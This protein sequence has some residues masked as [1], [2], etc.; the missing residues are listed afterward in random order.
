MFNLTECHFIYNDIN[1]RKYDLIVAHIDSEEFRPICGNKEGVY[2]F[3][4]A[5][6]SR[7][8]I[9][10]KYDGGSLTCK[11]EIVRCDG[12][13]FNKTELREAER[14]LFTNGKY[15]KLYIDPVD[16]PVGESYEISHGQQVKTYL[17]CRFVNAEKIF[18]NGGVIGFRCDIETDSYLAWQD[19]TVAYYVANNP[20]KIII[21]EG[22]TKHILLGD[23]QLDGEIGADD[24]QFAL[25][26][27]NY[28]VVADH[29]L[30][31][32]I[33]YMSALY[34]MQVTVDQIIACD[35]DFDVDDYED[36]I[37]G[38]IDPATGQPKKPDVSAEDP[39]TILEIYTASLAGYAEESRYVDPSTGEIVIDSNVRNIPIYVD[40]DIDGYTYPVITIKTGSVGGSVEITNTS[41]RVWPYLMNSYRR[42]TLQTQPNTEYVIDSTISSYSP[43]GVDIESGEFP[44]LLNG[45]NTLHFAGNIRTFKIEWNNRRFL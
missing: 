7:H 3:N 21:I 5:T 42:F 36:I 22:E 12:I 17:N 33:T 24:A 1:S 10:D 45:D 39:Q 20:E 27:Y 40:S 6:K 29:S 18:G 30:T 37:N 28:M 8:L 13:P 2:I 4:K 31:D 43:L 35:M 25:D 11:V 44:R 23:P 26:V 34:N 16:D 38:V 14:W 41:E 19:T 15:R 32:T 9:S